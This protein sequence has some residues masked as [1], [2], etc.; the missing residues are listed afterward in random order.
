MSSPLPN[1]SIGCRLDAPVQESRFFSPQRTRRALRKHGEQELLVFS[2][3]SPFSA[4]NSCLGLSRSRIDRV[5]PICAIARQMALLL[6]LWTACAIPSSG[7]PPTPAPAAGK[8]TAELT[9]HDLPATFSSR[10]NLVLVRVVVRDGQGH[11]IGTLKKE[12]FRL[13]DRG[14]PQ[15]IAKFSV[16]KT[17]A[18][19]ANG[20]PAVREP[21]TEKP[22]TP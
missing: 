1:G 12:E 14:K 17:G 19:E 15:V 18:N 22:E 8:N 5:H 21:T 11:A 4:V 20:E 6:L 7:Q 2:A 13:L 16:E 3:S 10:V 9:S